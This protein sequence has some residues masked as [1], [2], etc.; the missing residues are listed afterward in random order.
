MYYFSNLVIPIVFS[1]ILLYGLFKKIDVF[2]CFLCGAKEGIHTAVNILPALIAL[3]TG[4]AMLK[5]SGALDFFCNMLSPLT[6]FLGIPKE[7]LPQ[8][9]LRP[10]SG[11]GALAVFQDILKEH[12]PDSFIGRV[13]SVLQG[14]T[15]TTFYTIAVYLGA[16]N[17][18][19]TRHLIPSALSADIAGMILSVCAVKL[20]L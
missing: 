8:A 4:I 16:V 3:L 10:I 9:V 17:I 6:A 1:S 20:F 13:A 12:G 5:T 11:S 7:I 19:K 15:E 18:K 14:S 2:D